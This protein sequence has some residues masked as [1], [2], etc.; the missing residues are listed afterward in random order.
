M[1]LRV[2]IFGFGPHVFFSKTQ[3][4]VS[5]VQTPTLLPHKRLILRYLCL[6][7][8][9]SICFL[10]IFNLHPHCICTQMTTQRTKPA[11]SVQL[12]FGWNYN[13]TSVG[14]DSFDFFVVVLLS[15]VCKQTSCWVLLWYTST[16][17]TP[18]NHKWHHA[19]VKQDRK[20]VFR[21]EAA[22][23]RLNLTIER[24]FSKWFL[25]LKLLRQSLERRR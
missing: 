20:K 17:K 7:V 5:S 14:G 25:M 13:F 3:T 24:F 12:F 2:A 11:S 15:P 1:F 8:A 6:F 18:G 10:H 23:K 4:S 9:T 21:R 19:S 22:N 16:I